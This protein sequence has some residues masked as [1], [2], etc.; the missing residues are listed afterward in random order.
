MRDRVHQDQSGPVVRLGIAGLG[1]AGTT[2]LAAVLRHP[3][4]R[5][6]A[7]ADVR[8]EA[9][10]KFAA[11]LGGEAYEHVEDL[12]ASPNVDAIHVASPHQLH[13]A[14]T[15]A[16]AAHGKHVVLEKP[17]ALTLAECDA[18]VDA[19]K[20]HGVHL[21]V[22]RGSH[23]FDPPVLKMR[24][25]IAR[26]ALGR[27]G[28]I[29]NLQYAAFLY[30]PLTPAELL[31]TREGGGIFFNQGP[32]QT[33]VI[34]VIGGGL[35]RSVR[36]TTFAW[37]RERPIEGAYSAHL[38]FQDG[39]VATMIYSGY[40]RFDSDEFHHWLGT[41]GDPK[42]TD[43]HGAA[44]RDVQRMGGLEAEATRRADAGFGGGQQRVSIAE[45]RPDQHHA[46]FGVT[47]VSCERGDM[48]QSPDGISVFDDDGK[49]E[50]AVPFGRGTRDNVLDELYDAIVHD[51]PLMRDGRWGR[52]TI[53]VCLAILQSSKERREVTLS[54]QVLFRD[55]LLPAW[56]GSAS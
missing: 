34:R 3:G 15:L 36:A 56:L 44:R 7:G 24:Q 48:R 26:G 41:Y 18:M 11:D 55:D 46:H 45:E 28:M 5:V 21:L 12:C 13:A 23:G 42:R 8:K 17:M 50:V 14:H 1:T 25:L 38:E 27:L 54:R 10:A 9:R 43:R 39:A 31:P 22:G 4:F 19:A 35:V 49:R 2:L 53:E 29:T 51:R 16:A 6:T 30:S 52:A 40:D 47:I 20:R 33:D 32:H 37:D